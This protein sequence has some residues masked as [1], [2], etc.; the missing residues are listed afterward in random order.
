MQVNMTYLIGAFILAIVIVSMATFGYKWLNTSLL[1]ETKSDFNAQSSALQASIQS[2]V[3]SFVSN[4]EA[5]RLK[6]ADSCICRNVVNLPKEV[7]VSINNR[8]TLKPSIAINFMF[9][10]KNFRSNNIANLS[11]SAAYN[12]GGDV[13]PYEFKG[14]EVYDNVLNFE[15]MEFN[16]QK[17]ISN[18]IYKRDSKLYF[19]VYK[20]QL[21]KNIEEQRAF[22]ENSTA[23]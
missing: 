12:S 18:S 23:C 19:I 21:G 11:V 14:A 8:G 15:K 3:D 9:N 17:I 1:P 22:F 6:T 7:S 2:Q 10:G 16:G 20:S 13:K 5:C 4:L